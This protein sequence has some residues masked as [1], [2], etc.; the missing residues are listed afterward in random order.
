ME[1][2]KMKNLVINTLNRI[3]C[4]VSVAID[5][6]TIDLTTIKPEIIVNLNAGH[7]GKK[8]KTN[9]KSAIT[10]ALTKQGFEQFIIKFE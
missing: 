10:L 8:S 4:T 9:I 6:Y 1:K 2:E 3:A 7:Q 5:S